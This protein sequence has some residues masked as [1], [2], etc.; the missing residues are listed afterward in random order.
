MD[1]ARF[2]YIAQP[3]DKGV[4][5]MPGI[6]V[7]DKYSIEWGYRPFPNANSLEAE[8]KI[9]D[10]LILKHAGDKMYRF[11]KQT[12]NPIDP[13]SQ[14]EDLGDDAVKASAYGIANLKR[15]MPNIVTWTSEKGKDYDE[16]DEIYGQVLAQWNR[17]LGHVTTNIGGVYENYKT[18]EQK[19][20]VYEP[21]PQARQKIAMAFLID[22]AFETPTWMIDE[23]ILRRV[24]PAGSIERIRSA[25][26]N[27]LNN[28][29]EPGRMARLI[30]AETMNGSKAYGLPEMMAQLRSG[31]WSEL[32]NGKAIDTYRRSLQRGYI[33]RLEYLLKNEPAPI[34]AAMK[35][36]IGFTSVK[37]SQ[38]DI[39]PM[40]RGELKTLQ[41][42][43]RA[44]LPIAK[45]T[46]SRYHIEDAIARIEDILNPKG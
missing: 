16:L 30:E 20:V 41:R 8:K 12:M 6:G 37:V 44:A 33:E 29:L 2:N 45:D 23:N 36:F 25:Q 19:G 10:S 32:K 14:T 1:Y 13:S 42:D 27:V 11:G 24:E 5:L 38:S 22:Q 4:A 3:G 18:Y 35:E 43:L 28:L 31:I 15:I 39:R 9:L 40:A 17:Y 26:V 34:P 7:Y 46:I 21:V